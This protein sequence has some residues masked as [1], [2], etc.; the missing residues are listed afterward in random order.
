VCKVG[1]APTL[2]RCNASAHQRFNPSAGLT[3]ALLSHS[4]LASHPH[5]RGYLSYTADIRNVVQ[6]ARHA[7][8]EFRHEFGYE[9]PVD[10]LACKMADQFQ[11]RGVRCTRVM[12]RY[13]DIPLDVVTVTPF[14]RGV[15]LDLL[16]GLGWLSS[17][18]CA[19]W[20]YVL[21]ELS[22][23]SQVC[24]IPYRLSSN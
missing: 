6:K 12:G 20:P 3:H 24:K 7:A 1:Y 17:T 15:P 19:F 14:P 4:R 5:T 21:L 10:Y 9:I 8:A 2:Q 16:R 11:V 22:L 23:H 18:G 13:R